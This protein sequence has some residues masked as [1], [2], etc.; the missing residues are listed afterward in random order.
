MQS[1]EPEIFRI[2]A[3][4]IFAGHF[5]EAETCVAE[6]EVCIAGIDD[7]R[8]CKFI[9]A[10]SFDAKHCCNFCN[11]TCKTLSP[12]IMFRVTSYTCTTRVPCYV[13]VPTRGQ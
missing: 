4:V 5:C 12:P 2:V 8:N 11:Q 9:D 6:N 10:E 1:F 7:D 3:F 13:T